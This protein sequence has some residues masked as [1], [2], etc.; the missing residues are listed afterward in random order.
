[1]AS[2]ATDDAAESSAPR[3][4]KTI[5]LVRTDTSVDRV[6]G[7]I[8]FVWKSGKELKKRKEWKKR[9]IRF[10]DGSFHYYASDKPKEKS[11]GCIDAYSILGWYAKDE[12]STSFRDLTQKLQSS[13]VDQSANA[14]GIVFITTTRTWV[15]VCTE[16]QQLARLKRLVAIYARPLEI[17]KEG[18]CLKQQDSGFL[19]KCNRRYVA[20]RRNNVLPGVLLWATNDNL[21]TLRG[22]ARL[23]G[24][25][26]REYYGQCG[27]NNDNLWVAKDT[28]ITANKDRNRHLFV[29]EGHG[30]EWF[31]ALEKAT[32]LTRNH[33][34]KSKSPENATDDSYSTGH[35]KDH[36]QTLAHRE[37][38]RSLDKCSSEEMREEHTAGKK[39][40]K[41]HH[42]KRKS[43]SA[44][45]M[46][47]IKRAQRGHRSSLTFASEKVSQEE[48]P[49]W[50]TVRSIGSPR[51]SIAA[52]VSPVE[53]LKIRSVKEKD[54]L[55][56]EIGPGIKKERANKTQDSR[57]KPKR[58]S[59]SEKMIE[60]K[61]R[62]TS[63]G[64]QGVAAV[65]H[66]A[67]SDKKNGPEKSQR[68]DVDKLE[69]RS[70]LEKP[71]N[72]VSRSKSTPMDI[73]MMASLKAK[74]RQ[75]RTGRKEV[76]DTRRRLSSTGQDLLEKALSAVGSVEE[77]RKKQKALKEQQQLK[78]KL[79]R[80]RNQ[81]KQLKEQQQKR[82]EEIQRVKSEQD[83]YTDYKQ[84]IS[85]LMDERV[86]FWR[87]SDGINAKKEK[88][89]IHLMLTLHE[90]FPELFVTSALT[91]EQFNNFDDNH[92][93][94]VRKAYRVALL[95]VHPD[96]LPAN[97]TAEQRIIAEKVFD[98]LNKSFNKW[99]EAKC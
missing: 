16:P 32:K 47:S 14:A 18:Y 49:I 33:K 79:S 17:V 86:D 91:T 44:V 37:S 58:S 85:S 93:T 56:D 31:G 72:E 11:K 24:P 99:R 57:S 34:I 73:A 53:H 63:I 7:D 78:R 35:T 22:E 89:L 87:R 77:K 48:M 43:M 55:D 30:R 36:K 39:G 71:T 75:M 69:R 8:G 15:F 6:D 40:R 38:S 67:A 66:S 83:R 23:S 1:M 21:L 76:D 84:E 28:M 29:C 50:N 64:E 62:R 94:V 19:G 41:K 9:Y 59:V 51:N 88:N 90:H 10:L 26:G 70:M 74:E 12:R 42:E 60:G 13:V 65:N 80:Q 95:K 68:A 96:R 54:N 82:V 52:R 2:L 4:P 45:D 98:I 27:E 20:I 61:L 25:F 97:A 3:P 46:L 81:Q 5:R 92:T